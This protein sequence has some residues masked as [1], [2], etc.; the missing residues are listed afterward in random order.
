MIRPHVDPRPIDGDGNKYRVFLYT[1]LLMNSPL[2]KKLFALFALPTQIPPDT[3]SRKTE[4]PAFNFSKLV[5]LIMRMASS[6]SWW[7]FLLQLDKN[8]EH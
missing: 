2:K 4:L 3:C 6:A 1:S 5:M 8:L 7:S